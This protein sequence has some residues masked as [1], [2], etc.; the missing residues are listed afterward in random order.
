M[1]K[2]EVHLS[3]LVTNGEISRKEACK[4]LNK[5]LYKKNELENDMSYVLKKLDFSYK[6]FYKIMEEKPIPHDYFPNNNSFYRKVKK[7]F[8]DK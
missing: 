2:V 6:E 8:Y 4:E 3:A 5:L 7:L 1:K